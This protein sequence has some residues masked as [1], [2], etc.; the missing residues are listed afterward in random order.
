MVFGRFSPTAAADTPARAG[1]RLRHHNAGRLTRAE[2][3]YRRIVLEGDWFPDAF[4]GS[5][6]NLQRFD[7]GEDDA[8]VTSA[9]DGFQTMA[10]V[11]ACY[12]ANER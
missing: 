11:E 7:A 8:H 3:L 2:H 1:P 5:M 12:E 9:E 10:L 4:I 6:R